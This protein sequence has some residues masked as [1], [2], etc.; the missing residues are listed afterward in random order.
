MGCH[1]PQRAA[2]RLLR[3]VHRH[4]LED[5]ERALRR[6]VSVPLQDVREILVL[7]VECHIR[8]IRWRR[9]EHVVHSLLLQRLRHRAIDFEDSGA[10]QLFPAS[11]GMR[12]E[13]RAEDHDLRRTAAD[14]SLQRLIDEARADDHHPHDVHDLDISHRDVVGEAQRVDG[15]MVHI[16]LR[17]IAEELLGQVVGIARRGVGFPR[18]DGPRR[19]DI[20]RCSG[21]PGQRR[22]H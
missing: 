4:A 11:I 9:A 17:R 3:Q 22:S 13:P 14:G 6:I 8:Q 7:K 5:E 19:R 12:I 10:G 15:R 18:T 2:R 21:D 16:E 20:D 1:E